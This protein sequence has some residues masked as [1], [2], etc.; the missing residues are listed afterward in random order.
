MAE[1]EVP[2]TLVQVRYL[3]E[4]EVDGELCGQEMAP[5]GY[6]LTSNPPQFPHECP[7]G[8]RVTLWKSYPHL[9]PRP[10]P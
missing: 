3:C 7:A 2:V 5:T 1:R 8:H 6:R 9:D 4:A 10:T